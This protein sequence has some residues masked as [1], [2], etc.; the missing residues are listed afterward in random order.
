[1]FSDLAEDVEIIINSFKENP[2]KI[3]IKAFGFGSDD[4]KTTCQKIYNMFN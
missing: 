1:M 3:L 4:H 2:T